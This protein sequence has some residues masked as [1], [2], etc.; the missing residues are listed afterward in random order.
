MSFKKTF[1]FYRFNIEDLD[2]IQDITMNYC[3]S[4]EDVLVPEIEL[5][6]LDP[7]DQRMIR[8]LDHGSATITFED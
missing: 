4:G 1:M 2:V 5:S 7:D 3:L 6:L 8:N